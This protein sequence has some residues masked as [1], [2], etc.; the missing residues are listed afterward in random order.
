MSL[1]GHPPRPLRI[2]IFSVRYKWKTNN[3]C[4]REVVQAYNGRMSRVTKWNVLFFP[5]AQESS[6]IGH[7]TDTAVRLTRFRSYCSLIDSFN[8]ESTSTQRQL[9]S[10]VANRWK[11]LGSE[12]A[13]ITFAARSPS[14]QM[15][16]WRRPRDDVWLSVKWLDEWWMLKRLLLWGSL[17]F[18]LEYERGMA[19]GREALTL[20]GYSEEALFAI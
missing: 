5:G 14:S 13:L 9:I 15:Q 19:S 4:H 7:C 11:Y 10:N 16:Y 2:V 18:G 6:F 12:S 8:A 20:R 3:E 1:A 17:P